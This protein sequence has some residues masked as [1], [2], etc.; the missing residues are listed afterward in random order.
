[1]EE[2]RA[3][4]QRMGNHKAPGGDGTPAELLKCAGDAGARLL[5]VMFN[6]VWAAE[7]IPAG[8]RQGTVVSIYKADDPTNP[9]N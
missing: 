6:V 9:S 5:C 8:W 2:V 3:G 7:R 1:V 4:L